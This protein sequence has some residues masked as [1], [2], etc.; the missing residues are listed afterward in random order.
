[1]LG[2]VNEMGTWITRTSRA[3]VLKTAGSLSQVWLIGSIV[4]RYATCLDDIRQP[5]TAKPSERIRELFERWS[6]KF[7]PKY[8]EAKE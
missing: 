7:S 6:I 4:S 3:A 2:Y 8:Y 5:S 1:V